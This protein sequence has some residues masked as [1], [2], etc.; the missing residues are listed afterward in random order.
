MNDLQVDLVHMNIRKV[1]LQKV[2]YGN[3][4]R[5]GKFDRYGEKKRIKS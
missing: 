5:Q 4:Y 3:Q 1:W 2:E